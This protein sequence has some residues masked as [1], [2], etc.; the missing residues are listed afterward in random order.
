MIGRM[1]AL[2][3]DARALLAAKDAGEAFFQFIGRLVEE[4]G[5][6]KDF[7]DAL[8]GTGVDVA[9]AIGGIKLEMKGTMELLLKKAQ[10]KGAVRRDVSVGEVMALVMGTFGSIERMGVSARGRDRLM[11]IVCDGLRPPG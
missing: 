11:A 7:V 2:A 1:Q 3:A 8:A 6:K 9:R 5:K 4:G 10:R